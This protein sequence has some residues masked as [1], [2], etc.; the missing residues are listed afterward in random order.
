MT[1]EPIEDQHVDKLLND[2]Y[3]CMRTH[4]MERAERVKRQLDQQR[5]ALQ[6][7]KDLLMYYT[8][9]DFRYNVMRRQLT[10]SKELLSRVEA[11]R[12]ELTDLLNY[13]YHFFQG[14]YHWRQGE[15]RQALEQ[16][17]QAE[18]LLEKIPDPIEQA[19]FHYR[20]GFVYL[21]MGRNALSI[22]HVRKAQNL[23]AQYPDYETRF[24]DCENLLGGNYIE[25]KQYEE[26]EQCFIHALDLAQK[27]HDHELMMHVRSNLGFLY[28]EQRMSEAAIRHLTDVYEQKFNMYKTCFLLAREYYRLQEYDKAHQF[29]QEGID[30]CRKENNI[31]FLHRYNALRAFHTDQDINKL[32]QTIRAGIQ[33]CTSKELWKLV[34]EDGESLAR[35][36]Y[37]KNEYEKASY[38]FNLSYEAKE[39]IVEKEALT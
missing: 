19:E 20:V 9:L 8:L 24:A 27:H 5:E 12:Q 13:Y 31:E 6:Q 10:Q 35:R 34:Q 26:A 15:Y 14:M 39:K 2:W 21:D 7:D 17:W 16:Y 37:D 38:Y 23:F 28:S 25:L 4:D 29:V 33:Y 11:F 36:F 32:E 3:E 1:E 30:V 18:E 22:E